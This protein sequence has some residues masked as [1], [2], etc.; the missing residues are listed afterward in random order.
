[1]QSKFIRSL[2]FLILLNLLIKPFWLLGV[3]RTVQNVVGT[4]Q[5]GIYAVLLNMSLY[6]QIFLDPGL[7]TFNNT[8]LAQN[9]A[10]LSVQ[11]SRYVP[12]KIGLSVIYFGLTLGLG[13]VFGFTGNDF[14]LLVYIALM[15]VFNSFL[16]YMRSNLAGLMLL[17][18]DSVFS[19]LDRGLT[20]LVCATLFIYGLDTENLLRW[21]VYAQLF[22]TAFAAIAASFIVFRK[23]TF[24]KPQI[25]LQAFYSILKQTYPFALL[26]ILMTL[27]TRI[28]ILMIE[29]MLP[30][31]EYQAGVYAS[32]YRLLEAANMIAFLFAGIL[33]PVFASQLTD[34]QEVKKT[35]TLGFR[36]LWLPGLLIVLGAYFYRSEIMHMLYTE[37]T[38]YSADVFGFIMPTFLALCTVYVYG[39]L[40]TA[41][42]NLTFLNWVAALGLIGNILLNLFLI[43]KYGALGAVWATLFTQTLVA[44]MQYIY[45]HRVFAMGLWSTKHFPAIAYM[46]AAVLSFYFLHGLPVIWYVNLLILTLANLTF[47]IGLGLLKPSFF[48]NILK[49]NKLK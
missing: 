22:C 39:T 41:N 11:L 32:G 44:G 35:A 23:A 29:Q 42:H 25:K 30:D 3:D 31:G 19:V 43:P 14:L 1:M 26:A 15:Q 33:L 27:Y 8:L 34:K 20:I 7:H 5:Y 17:N 12:L 48:L 6:L 40:L 47:A 24:F 21:F 36:L 45:A 16:L 4:A 10:K 9:P 28:D 38:E 46:A 18:T 49:S 13:A 2:F 37:A